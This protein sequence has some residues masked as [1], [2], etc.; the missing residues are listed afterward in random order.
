M[1]NFIYKFFIILFLVI[2]TISINIFLNTLDFNTSNVV[3]NTKFLSMDFFKGRLAGTKENENAEDYIKNQFTKEKLDPYVSKFYDNFKTACPVRTAGEPMFNITDKSGNII[4]KLT[5]DKDY[6]EDMLNFRISDFKGTSDDTFYVDNSYIKIQGKSGKIILNK[7][8]KFDFRSSF[9]SNAPYDLY[10]SVTED[11]FNK[12]KAN[13]S[14]GNLLFISIPMKT[15]IK[16]ISNVAGYIKGK[17]PGLQPL[18]LCAHFDHVGTDLYDNIYRGSF[19]NASGTSFMLELSRYFRNLPKPDRD[20]IFVGFNAE[21]FGLKGS[22]HFVSQYGDVLLGSRVYNF[23]MIG[24]SK[25]YPICIMGGSKDTA[26]STLMRNTSEAFHKNNLYYS[27]LFG[28]SSDHEYFRVKGINA[29][30]IVHNDM[31]FIHTLSDTPDKINEDSI[32]MCFKGL[33]SEFLSYA[34]INSYEVLYS[35][36]IAAISFILFISS[37]YIFSKK[38]H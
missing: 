18:I 5:Y 11:T 34:Y 26:S 31:S 27:I 15:E 4:V 1:K 6:K 3:Q 36:E 28:E 2:F 9:L 19:D 32:K 13:L 38:S 20:I 14:A 16:E 30:T 10:I 22:C 33:K 24:G 17:N 8:D 21:E 29:V 23:D 35:K 7:N 25:K 12:V 37:L